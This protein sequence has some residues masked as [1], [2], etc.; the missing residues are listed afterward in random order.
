MRPSRLHHQ[1]QKLVGLSRGWI[2]PRHCE[3]LIGMMIGLI[4]SECINLP[5]WTV[6]LQTCAV[7][8]QSHPRRFSRWLN[9]ARIN[10]Q[11]LYSPLITDDTHRARAFDEYPDS[12]D[13]AAQ[14]LI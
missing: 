13:F 1:L 5:R 7:F 3:T 11:K 2:D 6:Y 4:C 8:V 12:A 10:V 9:N 14:I